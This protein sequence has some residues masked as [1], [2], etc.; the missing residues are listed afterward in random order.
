MIWMIDIFQKLLDVY[1]Q[2]VLELL[3][4]IYRLLASQEEG[5]FAL[6]LQK[7]PLPPQISLHTQ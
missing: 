5:V 1:A 7:N 3:Q 4:S 6:C 2:I